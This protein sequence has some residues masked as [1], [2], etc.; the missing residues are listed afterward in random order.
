VKVNVQCFK[1]VRV[2]KLDSNPVATLYCSV[3]QPFRRRGTLDLALHISRYPLTVPLEDNAYFLKLIC[4]LI[5]GERQ[6]SLLL[7][8]FC[9]CV[10][11]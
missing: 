11:L 6:S 1:L 8:S 7:L 5:I 10:N 4:F 9:V 3:S 2:I